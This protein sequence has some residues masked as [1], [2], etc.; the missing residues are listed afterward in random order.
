MKRDRK[1]PQTWYD[2]IGQVGFKREKTISFCPSCLVP[3]VPIPA[4]GS[5][6]QAWRPPHPS[7]SAPGSCTC[8]SWSP[9]QMGCPY[10][11]LQARGGILRSHAAPWR[12]G[13]LVSKHSPSG[14]RGEGR[15]KRILDIFVT[16]S[17]LK[18]TRHSSYWPFLGRIANPGSSPGFKAAFK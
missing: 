12:E 16:G 4:K 11:R 9:Q 18:A 17:G 14:G 15:W 6:S 1:F 7:P 5:G 10:H 8:G 3:S 13:D 2:F